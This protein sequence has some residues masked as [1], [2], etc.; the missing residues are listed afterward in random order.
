MARNKYPE[1][2]VNLILDV[3][4]KLF[5]E[6]GYD[7]TSIQDIIDHLGGLSKGAIYHHFKSK[8]SI[9]VAIFDRMGEMTEHQMSAIRDEK[10]L[11]G[12]EKL[13]KMFASS[14]MD[15]D[16]L[17]MFAAAPNLIENPRLLAM[18][19]V[20]MMEDVVPNYI[21]PVIRQGIEDSSIKTDY[22]KELGEILILMSNI[23]MNPLVY[24]MTREEIMSKIAFF[25]QFTEAIGVPIMDKGL[26]QRLERFCEL[27]KK[28]S[29]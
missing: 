19:M 2:T 23:W 8:E 20:S 5:L 22:P 6:K 26:E 10:S 28:P 15:S 3:S 16:S 27:V 25:K 4:A 17:E 24:S 29:E 9:L 12:L 1:E 18:Q 13:K 21:E 7:E 11:T 14:L